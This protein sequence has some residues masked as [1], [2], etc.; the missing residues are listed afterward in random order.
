MRLKGLHLKGFR[1]HA[2]NYYSKR[3][4]KDYE[5][6]Q[7]ENIKDG[8]LNKELK[9]LIW[10]NLLI[11][12]VVIMYFFDLVTLLN[13][14]S[15]E[16]AVTPQELQQTH[17]EY[18]LIPKIIHQTYKTADIPEKWKDCQKQCI[19]LHKHYRY[20]LWTDEKAREF[21]SQEYPWFVKEWD[22]YKYPIQRADAL[23]YFVLH[24]YGGIYIDLD[25]ACKRPLD[26]LLKLPAFVRK[27]EPTGVSNDVMGT[28]P[29]HPF[30]LKVIQSLKQYDKN[31]LLPYVTIMY[32][33]G[34]LF[35]SAMLKEYRRTAPATEHPVRILTPSQYA[36]FENSFFETGSGN[37]WHQGDAQVFKTMARYIFLSVIAGFLLGFLI[38][39][40]EYVF[41]RFV[42]RLYHKYTTS[43][44]Y[45]YTPLDTEGRV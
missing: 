9:A 5:D 45:R 8:W 4:T 7:K 23:R 1:E 34:P 16:V 43:D 39:Y 29:G 25:D 19:D 31:W 30:F 22:N 42:R 27:T 20:I 40:L 36:D 38:L 26:A 14:D 35:L 15:K 10:G 12:V 21:I 28:V 6:K 17:G 41:I 3:N 44:P 18:T 2:R 11:A 32:S 37:S 33:T 24:L 13:E